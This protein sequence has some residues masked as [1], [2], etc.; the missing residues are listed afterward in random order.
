MVVVTER[1]AFMHEGDVILMAT[2]ASM[3]MRKRVSSIPNSI[4]AK[5]SRILFAVTAYP[6]RVNWSVAT[7]GVCFR[8]AA[9]P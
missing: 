4:H 8:M 9:N 5:V 7:V 1:I 2:G 6:S 3:I